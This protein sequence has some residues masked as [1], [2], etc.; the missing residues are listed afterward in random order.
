MFS[1]IVGNRLCCIPT[2]RCLAALPLVSCILH[3]QCRYV[4]FLEEADILD[5]ADSSLVAHAYRAAAFNKVRL[6]STTASGT[7]QGQAGGGCGDVVFHFTL[8]LPWFLPRVR[9]AT[10][11]ANVLHIQQDGQIVVAN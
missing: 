6:V 7:M 10:P 11:S 1:F 2:R 4:D 3:V 8:P 5:L 9:P